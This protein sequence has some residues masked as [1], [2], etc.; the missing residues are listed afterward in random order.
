M[1]LLETKRGNAAFVS[2]PCRLLLI[3]EIRKNS[4]LIQKKCTCYGNSQTAITHPKH[5]KQ[6]SKEKLGEGPTVKLD[7]TFKMLAFL[8]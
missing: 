8:A 2:L 4:F 7:N 1:R 5:P 6:G 3:K